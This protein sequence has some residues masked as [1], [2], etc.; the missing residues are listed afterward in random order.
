MLVLLA[1]IAVALLLARD[2]YDPTLY[3]LPA[4]PGPPHT[5]PVRPASP[6]PAAGF[7]PVEPIDGPVPEAAR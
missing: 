7:V 4:P 5:L 6:E 3:R 2:H 1:G